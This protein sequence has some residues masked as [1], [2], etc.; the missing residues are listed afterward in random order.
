MELQAVT[1]EQVFAKLCEV[2][3]LLKAKE[4][5]EHSRELWGLEEIANYFG[6]TKEHTSRSIIST[7]NFP[8]AIYVKGLRG[9]GRKQWVSGE[10]VAFCLKWK[11][12]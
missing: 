11:V 8:R 2:E 4:V 10:V 9:R 3:R 5:N 12:K 7:P 1:N 6:Y